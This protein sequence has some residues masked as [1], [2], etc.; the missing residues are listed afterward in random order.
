MQ[1]DGSDN[2]G[3]TTVTPWFAVN[4]NHTE[5]NAEAARRDPGSVF[6]HSQKLIALRHDDE[7]VQ[8]GRFELLLA[9]HGQLW[10]FTP[11]LGDSRLLVLANCSST[12]VELP[13]VGLPSL[14]DA[15]LVLGNQDNADAPILD[16]WESRIVRLSPDA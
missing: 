6:A 12:P 3:F 8:E 11:T 14:V 16:P 4:P 10:A 5:I 13:D 1:W 2:A 15:E 7:V 9:D